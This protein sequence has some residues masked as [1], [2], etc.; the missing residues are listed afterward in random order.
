[1]TPHAITLYDAQGHTVLWTLPPSGQV[2]RLKETVYDLAPIS[3]AGPAGEVIHIPV[4]WKTYSGIYGLPREEPGIIYI[5][6]MPVAEFVVGSGRKDFVHPDT[7]PDGAVRGEGGVILGCRALV[8]VEPSRM[9][10]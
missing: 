3:V 7:G 5:V 9:G 2:I 8:K 10:V 4:K 1:M 6:S